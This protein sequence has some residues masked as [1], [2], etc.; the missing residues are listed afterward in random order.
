MM[1]FIIQNQFRLINVE[2][3]LYKK[4]AMTYTKFFETSKRIRDIIETASLKGGILP[5]VATNKPS[6]EMALPKKK[7]AAQPP[8][9]YKKVERTTNSEKKKRPRLN[10]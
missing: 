6:T 2:S 8:S 5:V 9:A 1:N 7:P 10:R 3:D 4:K